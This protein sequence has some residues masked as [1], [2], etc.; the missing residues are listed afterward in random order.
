MLTGGFTSVAP[1]GT[2]SALVT[3]VVGE[4]GYSRGGGGGTFWK[5]P[6]SVTA[7]QSI[8]GVVGA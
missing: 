1:V 5:F 7:G 8:S 2:N 6:V 4:N 3:G